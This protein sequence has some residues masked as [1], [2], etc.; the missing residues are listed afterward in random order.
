MSGS[1]V[2]FPKTLHQEGRRASLAF[3]HNAPSITDNVSK[4]AR[5]LDNGR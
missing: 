2:Q 3:P 5:R 4:H 1:N